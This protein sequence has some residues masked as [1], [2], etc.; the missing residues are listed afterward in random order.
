MARNIVTALLFMVASIKLSLASD[1]FDIINDRQPRQLNAGVE[2][3]S[4]EMITSPEGVTCYPKNRP[5]RSQQNATTSIT[6]IAPSEV[7]ALIIKRIDSQSIN[8]ICI[9]N[10]AFYALVGRFV[11]PYALVYRLVNRI[12]FSPYITQ[13]ELNMLVEDNNIFSPNVKELIFHNCIN[14]TDLTPLSNCSNLTKID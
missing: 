13:N 3:T 9:V 2:N 1:T 6:D 5:Y 11:T 12:E 10:K 14:I 8:N 7:W 4:Q